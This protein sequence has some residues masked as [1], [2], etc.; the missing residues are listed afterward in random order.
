VTATRPA[1]ER[2]PDGR[3]RVAGELGFAQ[4]QEALARGSLLYEGA[5]GDVDVDLAGLREVD[6]AT[7]AVLL[8]W[9]ARAARGGVA[10]RFTGAPASLQALARL[11]D[12]APLLGIEA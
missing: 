1:I 10:L 12:A 8:A 2:L 9:S 7:L 6:S 4:A 11:C 5:S 3:R